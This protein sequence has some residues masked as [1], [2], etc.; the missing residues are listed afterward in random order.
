M[1]DYDM[2]R[3]YETTIE[4]LKDKGIEISD[5]AAIV[6]ELQKDYVPV[7]MDLC[8]EHVLAV[9]R[10]RETIHAVLTA[11]AIDKAVEQGRFEEPI[12]SIIAKDEGLYGID[13]VL[14]LSIVNIYGSIGLTNFGFLDKNKIGII[15]ELDKRKGDEV[16]TFS[17]DMVAAIAAAAASRLA[18]SNKMKEEG[19][20]HE[21]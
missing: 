6:Y 8:E 5:I 4:A 18:H 11:L 16:T 21:A 3:L 19:E 17:D 9:L 2:K 15:D 14:S 20:N 13:E 1:Y 12:Q 7:T 10:K